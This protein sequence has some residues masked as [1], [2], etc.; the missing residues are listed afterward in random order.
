MPPGM[1]HISWLT[2]VELEKKAAQ[3]ARLEALQEAAGMVDH[4]CLEG[5][6]TYGDAIRRRITKEHT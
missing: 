3:K 6:G 5:G 4:I 1:L 2:L